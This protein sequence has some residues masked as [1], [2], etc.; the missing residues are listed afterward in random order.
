[1]TLVAQA[2]RSKAAASKALLVQLGIEGMMPSRSFQDSAELYS[3][4]T[5]AGK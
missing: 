1:V 2:L 3:E 4:V 5:N